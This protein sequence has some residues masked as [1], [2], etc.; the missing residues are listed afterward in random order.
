MKRF[1]WFYM[2]LIILL[3]ACASNGSEAECKEGICV[4]LEVEGP[5]EALNPT[6]FV[7]S[8]KTD[9]DIN[10]LGISL[11]GDQT[12]TILDIVKKPDTAKLV[13]QDDRSMG[14][15]INS[16]SGEEYVFSGHI[17]LPKPTV[18]YGIFNYGLIAAAGHPSITQVTDSITIYLDAEGKQIEESQAMMELE[19]VFP[20]PTP[21]PDMT[22]VPETPL[23]TI[24]WPTD[25]PLPSPSPTSPAYP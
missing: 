7:I 23:P 13:Y 15:L 9:K 24:V 5:V 4:N 10:N 18:S 14:W 20:A 22:I 19:T 12:I 21:R 16:K 8:V 3:T 1:F 11:L 6:I 25:T 2:L 17:I